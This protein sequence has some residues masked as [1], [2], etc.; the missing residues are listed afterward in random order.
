MGKKPPDDHSSGKSL[1]AAIDLRR[2]LEIPRYENWD[3][4]GSISEKAKAAATKDFS[5]RKWERQINDEIFGPLGAKKL[6]VEK[7]FES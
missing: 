7:Q 4:A 5:E 2:F 1:A 6:V 3:S